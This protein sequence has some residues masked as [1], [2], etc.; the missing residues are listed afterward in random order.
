M[1]SDL[2]AL[3]KN[4]E[5]VFSDL[6]ELVPLFHSPDGER[7]GVIEVNGHRETWSLDSTVFRNLLDFRV[8]QRYGNL[9]PIGEVNRIIRLLKAK[10]QFEAPEIPVFVRVAF[11]NGS[12][13]L[14]LCNEK[15]EVVKITQ[16]GWRVV[17]DSPVRFTRARGM[18]PLPHP[19]RGG[20][21]EDFKNLTNAQDTNVWLSCLSWVIGTLN[22]KG[23]F[24][25]LN[26]EGGSGRAKSAAVRMIRHVIDPST[27]PLR[28][29]PD[30]VRDL[31]IA[32]KDSWILAF[33]NLSKVPDWFS[34]ALCRLA[35]GGGF[36]TR[37][38]FTDGEQFIIN[39][40]RPVV[41][42]GIDFLPA[43]ED[44]IDRSL[45]ITLPQIPND[46]RMA[47]EDLW[48]DFEVARPK[49]LGALLDVISCC[50]LNMNKVELKSY[51]R[52][53]DFMRWVTAS[54]PAIGLST[55]T[56]LKIYEGNRRSAIQDSLERDQVASVL[57]TLLA[58]RKSWR[59]TATA[60]L[61]EL[62]KCE[63]DPKRR[64]ASWPKSASELPGRLKRAENNLL[65]VG[66]EIIFTREG[67]TGRRI[68]QITSKA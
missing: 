38:L 35:T 55:G 11:Y 41:I 46:K 21:L 66:V 64:G 68:I 23:P 5:R 22:P 47:M 18:L 6:S 57:L 28:P 27:A 45:V 13:F 59:G 24:P 42:N 50:L 40:I 44:F 4:Q 51:P 26:V 30:S 32:S 1:F 56:F 53:A 33:D 29:A 7:Y 63:P 9:M 8:Y 54:E 48:T 34:D 36:S 37:K 52:M 39:T 43:R 15:W 61:E 10:A 14:D 62:K 12:I 65:S 3:S 20:K 25:I 31:M 19:Q 60:L 16:N 67:G 49:I 17:Q 58:S 2:I